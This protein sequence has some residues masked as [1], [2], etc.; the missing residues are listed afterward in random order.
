M[1]EKLITSMVIIHGEHEDSM[2]TRAQKG[3]TRIKIR[4]ARDLVETFKMSFTYGYFK[5]RIIEVKPRQLVSQVP[6]CLFRGEPN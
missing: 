6:S 4:I 3:G 2:Q 5:L 1:R